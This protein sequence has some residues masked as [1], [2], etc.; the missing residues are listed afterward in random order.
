LK[1]K[2][3]LKAVG[4]IIL[5]IFLVLAAVAVGVYFY[6]RNRF[7]G[8][9]S[10]NITADTGT[11]VTVAGGK[12]SGGMDGDIYTYLGVPY[13]EAKERFVPAEE[14]EPW[15][16]VR[17]YTDYGAISPQASY[18]GSDGQDNNCQN[19]NIWTPALNDGGKRP[20]MVWLHGGGFSSGTANQTETNGKNLAEGE[21]VVVVTVNHRLGI[22]GYL[23]LSAYDE[24][25]QYSGNA[26][27]MDVIDALQW[28]Q[29]NIEVF[30]GDP[31]NITVFG[32]SGGGAKVLTLMSSPYADGLFQKGI[33]QSGATETVGP[34]LTSAEVSRHITDLVL[35]ELHITKEN[36]EDLQ[37]RSFSELN[38][39]GTKALQ[40]TAEEYKIEGPFGGSYSY[41]WMPVV[42]GD[43]LPTDPVTEDGF[44]EAGK[45]IPILIGSN[46]NEW[47]TM[48][49]GAD[50]SMTEEEAL[51]ELENRYGDTAQD[52][53]EAFQEAYPGEEACNAL[54]TDSMLRI[55]LLRVM[56]YKA[57][58][59]GAPVYAYLFTYGAPQCVHGAEIPYVFGNTSDS[60]T[61]SRSMEQTMQGVWA[62]FARTGVPE[63]G[64]VPKWPAYTR[65]EGGTMILDT[66]PYVGYQH[67]LKLLNL[68]KPGFD[69]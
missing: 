48:M 30:G 58:Q 38:D 16:G 65:E 26:G 46:L 3:W 64:G 56:A 15:E 24:K 39:A 68:L 50:A 49:G 8:S 14:I 62:S 29:D 9:P 43:F 13:A 36:I 6:L 28:I 42:D 45:D 40:Q 2:K 7:G 22:S 32:Q 11:E 31:S 17:A 63:A 54:Y 66:E 20:V 4:I 25:Y 53:L 44:A 1:K 37:D 61:D 21:D 41:E 10:A 12:I 19:L 5:V 69:Y 27:M 35:E 59:G 51:S 52:I 47:E 55:P 34:V 18:F 67:D 33:I 57:D 60:G 23:N